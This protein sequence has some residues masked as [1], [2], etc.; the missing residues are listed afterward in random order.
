MQLSIS[1]RRIKQDKETDQFASLRDEMNKLF[2]QF[3]HSFG[4]EP[5]TG[6][7]LAEW[8]PKVNLAET[9]KELQVTAELPGVEEKDVQVTIDQGVLTI[10]GEKKEEKEEKNKNYYR[11][12]RSFGSFQRSFS[13]PKDVEE[14]KIEASFNNGVLSVKLPKNWEAQQ[15]AKMIPI[16]KS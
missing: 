2:E 5:F 11:V 6:G 8:T 14:E 7:A 1:P 4:I 12:E 9:E 16:N 13:L 3:S 10:K 15:S